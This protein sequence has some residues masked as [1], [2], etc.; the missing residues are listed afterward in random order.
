MKN[1]YKSFGI[2]F[3]LCV[4][5]TGVLIGI[6]PQTTYAISQ[7]SCP[8]GSTLTWQRTKI[9][10]TSDWSCVDNTTQAISNP[11]QGEVKQCSDGFT[12]SADTWNNAICVPTTSA[13]GRSQDFITDPNQGIVTCSG[14]WATLSN[15]GTCIFRAFA[16]GTGS[17]FITISAWLLEIAGSIF[18]WLV[19]YS[20]IQFG[21][22]GNA[23]TLTSLTN[24]INVGWSLFRDISNIVIIGLFTFIA[25]ATILGLKEYGY[26]KLVARVL[27]IAVLINFSLLFTKLIVDGSNFTAYQFYSAAGFET[28]QSGSTSATQGAS[29]VTSQVTDFTQTGVA[30]KFIKFMGVTSIGDT[31]STLD[32]GADAL[33]NGWL[34][35]LHG[36]FAAAVLLGAA[37]VLFY[38]SFLLVTRAIVII[39]LMLT[40]SIAFATH[41]VPAFDKKGWGLWWESLIKAAVFAPILMI[42]LWITTTLADGLQTNKGGSLGALLSDPSNFSNLGSL[43]SY[44]MILGLLYASFKISSSFASMAGSINFGGLATAG[45]AAATGGVGGFAL[46]NSVGRGANALNERMMASAQMLA[47]N[48]NSALARGIGRTLYSGA[49]PLKAVAGSKSFG[50]FSGTVKRKGEAYGKMAHDLK[51]TDDQK[52]GVRAEAEKKTLDSNPDLKTA[53]SNSATEAQQAN[54]AHED[55]KKDREAIVV[56]ANKAISDLKARH[57]EATRAAASDSSSTEKQMAAESA[58]FRLQKQQQESQQQLKEQDARISKAGS[59]LKSAVAQ[60]ETMKQVVT[61]AAEQSG[62]MAVDVNKSEANLAKELAHGRFTNTLKGLVGMK[63]AADSD[64]VAKAAAKYVGDH[65]KKENREKFAET[66]GA[67]VDG[68]HDE[69]KPAAGAAG[70]A[71]ANDGHATGDGH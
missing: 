25:I 42:F 22:F 12:Q 36:L 41:L 29:G 31:F 58:K 39:I 52:K 5:S 57:E 55:A 67:K 61:K 71:G 47:N 18:D 30:G 8:T 37:L 1:Y 68:G 9:L 56:E 65:H 14:T 50:D 33:Q 10:V 53:H 13:S 54:T 24:G 23:Q 62:F 44:I 16:A 64:R 48:K 59:A 40:A 11:T 2:L 32:K 43:F 51:L 60:H 26:K 69:K 49:Q 34:V 46:R 63:P 17:I 35:L 15:P 27:I 70:A 4:F 19:Y 38:G 45:L 66:M 7:Y 28:P 20:V 3:A 6:L 21:S